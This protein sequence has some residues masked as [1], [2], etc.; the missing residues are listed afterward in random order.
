MYNVECKTI[1]MAVRSLDG[2]NIL[3]VSGTIS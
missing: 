1:I 2:D 3:I